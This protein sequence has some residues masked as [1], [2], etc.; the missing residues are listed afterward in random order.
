M[1]FVG[2]LLPHILNGIA[3]GLFLFPVG[4]VFAGRWRDVHPVMYGLAVVF[5]AH[6]LWRAG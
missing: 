1:E 6:F 5:A 3:L 2:Y 4:M